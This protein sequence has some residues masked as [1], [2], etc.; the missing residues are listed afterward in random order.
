MR[1]FKFSRYLL[2]FCISTLFFVTGCLPPEA[3]PPRPR[4][5]TSPPPGHVKNA[6]PAWAPAHGRK[7][8][9][10]YHYYYYPNVE[11]YFDAGRGLYF[12]LERGAWLTSARLPGHI[13]ISISNRV[14]LELDGDRP[15]YYHHET[16]KKYP[17]G[18]AKKK[19]KHK[20]KKHKKDKWR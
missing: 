14:S 15:Y 1:F 2:I 19:H 7:A 8:K 11:V 18:Q 17:P 12:Y 10:R 13:N 5:K 9:L 20:N 6:P 3:Y 4:V 16:V